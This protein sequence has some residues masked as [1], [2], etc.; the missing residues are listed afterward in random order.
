MAE[1]EWTER[2]EWAARWTDTAVVALDE[3]AQAATFSVGLVD[4]D[5]MSL[6]SLETIVRERLPRVR[7]LWAQ[8][9]GNEAVRL[10][11]DEA[12]RPDVVLMDMS[13]ETLPGVVACRRIRRYDGS[14]KLLAITCY[15]TK[16]FVDAAA[17]SGAQGISTKNDENELVAA[18]LA[19]A[20]GGTYGKGMFESAESAHIRLSSQTG[21]NDDVLSVR[22]S[23]V[24]NLI[25]QGMLDEDIAG[26]LGVS[27]A[28]VR[29]H[30]QTASHK[31]GVHN[32]VQAMLAWIGINNDG[33]WDRH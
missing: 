25:A 15:A 32:R 16:V 7:L 20:S 9:D 33:R 3:R 24:M 22:E 19:V 31:M 12:T 17:Q 1:A 29:K 5:T 14:V 28:T 4:N 21:G 10:C 13:M 6:K 11:R 8:P 26:Q 18:T 30:A 27:V 2:A 23:E